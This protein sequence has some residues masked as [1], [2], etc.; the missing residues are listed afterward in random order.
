M[1]DLSFKYLQGYTPSMRLKRRLY[2]IHSSFFSHFHSPL[3]LYSV[4]FLLFTYV[5]EIMEDRELILDIKELQVN[6]KV[7]SFVGNPVLILWIS[8]TQTTA[9]IYTIFTIFCCHCLR[10]IT[11][12]EAGSLQIKYV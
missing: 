11:F 8:Q 2:N 10:F 3:Q 4:H 7:S 1:R 5:K 6:I 9:N 12:L